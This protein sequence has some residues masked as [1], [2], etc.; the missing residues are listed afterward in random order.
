MRER[1]QFSQEANH[2]R[3]TRTLLNFP[4]AMESFERN[5]SDLR[6]NSKLTLQAILKGF[7]LQLSITLENLFNKKKS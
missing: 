4:R 3:N 7:F 1:S 6:V 5:A 2:I